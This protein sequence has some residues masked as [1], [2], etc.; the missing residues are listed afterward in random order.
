MIRGQGNILYQHNLIRSSVDNIT[1][2]HKPIILTKLKQFLICI[3]SC[4]QIRGG[5]SLIHQEL[6]NITVVPTAGLLNVVQ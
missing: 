1:Y 3:G 6:L 2:L 5:S 4:K